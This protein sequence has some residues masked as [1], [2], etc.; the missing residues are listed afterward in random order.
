MQGCEGPWLFLKP[1]GSMS[2]KKFGKH[3]LGGKKLCVQSTE[4]KKCQKNFEHGF[5]HTQSYTLL[6]IQQ[7]MSH[8]LILK[9]LWWRYL[10]TT[11]SACPIV[12]QSIFSTRS[13]LSLD[14]RHFVPFLPQKRIHEMIQGL[15][16]AST[17]S[18]NAYSLKTK[19]FQNSGRDM[20][21]QFVYLP[22]HLFSNKYES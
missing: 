16:S 12:T 17:C 2:K 3:C 1:E 18:S 22:C 4:K 7:L 5:C 8:L 15:N 6:Y 20:C 13:F 11:D 14:M 9:F 21:L 10:N 19:L